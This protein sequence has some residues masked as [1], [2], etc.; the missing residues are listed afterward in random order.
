MKT[1]PR[2]IALAVATLPYLL[3]ACSTPTTPGAPRPSDFPDVP[4]AI[5]VPSG[6]TLALTLKGSGLQNY[7]C[8]AK[9]GAA[10]GYDWTLIGPEAALR[11]KSDA[12]VGRHYAG[13]AWEYGDGSKVTGK[14]VADVASPGTGNIPWLL[15]KGTPSGSGQLAGV[16]YIQ[17]LN[18]SGGTAPS[19]P[20]G[21]AQAGTKKS[22]RYSADYAFYK[23]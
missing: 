8:R 3:A 11:D 23:G 10:G 21:A 1:S 6:N 4:A 2:T 20:C 7:E 5:A 15:L 22:T 14:V 17:R 18:T 13:P 19:D 12:L 9:S 16:T